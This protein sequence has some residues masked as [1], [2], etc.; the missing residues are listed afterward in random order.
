MGL[1]EEIL[2][3]SDLGF[4]EVA[5]PEWGG[6][7]VRLAAMSAAVRDQF[8]LSTYQD[9]EAAK[10]AGG[11]S[12]NVRARM[13]VFS[14]VDDTGELVFKEADIPAL[15]KKSAKA[16]DRIYDAAKKLN[17]YSEAEAKELEKN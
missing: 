15:G 17:G 2:A 10:K 3:Q 1:K 16:L 11:H 13:A 14:I 7:T 9:A 6:T 12:T 5:V 4:V 8:E